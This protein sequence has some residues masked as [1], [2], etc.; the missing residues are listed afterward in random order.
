M[1]ITENTAEDKD[2]QNR[3]N[4]LSPIRPWGPGHTVNVLESV[5]KSFRDAFERTSSSVLGLVR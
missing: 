3:R 4:R 2:E 1:F 5:M